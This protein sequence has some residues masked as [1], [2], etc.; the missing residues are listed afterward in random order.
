MS[1]DYG[2]NDPCP[3]GSGK[4]F[5]K[6][7]IGREH[8]L[9]PVRQEAVAPVPAPAFRV[10]KEKKLHVQDG[11]EALAM[12]QEMVRKS[13]DSNKPEIR[14][15]VAQTKEVLTY[16]ERQSQIEAAS[17]ALESKREEFLKWLENKEAYLDRARDLFKENAFVSMRFSSAEV[18]QACIQ[19]GHLVPGIVAGD[20]DANSIMAAILSLANSE[21]RQTLSL[22]LLSLIPDYVAAGRYMDGWI[23]RLCAYDTMDKERESNPFLYNMFV[24]GYD[25]WMQIE[26][27]QKEELLRKAGLDLDRLRTMKMDEIEAFFNSMKEDPAQKAK[28]EQILA[29]NP[30]VKEQTTATM[31]KME[32]QADELFKRDDFKEF[33]LTIQDIEPFGP[34]IESRCQ[35]WRKQHPEI[36]F[37]NLSNPKTVEAVGEITFN[38]L[39]EMA[40]SLFTSAR[41]SDLVVRLKQYRNA[42]LE[43]GDIRTAKAAMGAII[44]LERD[45]DNPQ[46]NRFLLRLCFYSLNVLSA[47]QSHDAKA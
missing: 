12:L 28:L 3:C 5:K 45:R 7:H 19:A 8:Q 34:R 24:H 21:R 17:N 18:K 41:I 33:H 30:N 36:D 10:Q 35:E 38:F 46:N 15:L 11:K 31:Q 4:K 22:K 9:P 47:L 13:A 29:A 1:A 6:C 42:R 23:V 20:E 16:Y 25:D 40:S 2:R 27:N 26:R 37:E 32:S 43:E 44:S 14:A 39:C